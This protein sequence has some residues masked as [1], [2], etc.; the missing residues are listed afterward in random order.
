MQSVYLIKFLVIFITVFLLYA[1]IRSQLKISFLLK[2]HSMLIRG[3]I[4]LAFGTLSLGIAEFVAMG[5]LPYIANDFSVSLDTAGHII[6]F[7]ASGVA[8][9]A[10]SLLFL[11]R[12]K[13]KY[14]IL[15]LIIVHILGNALTAFA[16]DFNMLLLYRFISG[17]PHGCYFGVGSIIASR[18]ATAGKGTSAIAIMGAGM[19]VAN[20]FGVP[21]GT[22]MADTLSWRS[23]FYLVTLWGIIVLFSV[24]VFVKDTGKIADTGFKGQFV[25]LK[26]KAPWLILGATMFSNGGIFCL[27]SYLS[28]IL[29]KLSNIPLPMVSI[30]MVAMGICMVLFNLLSGKLCDKFAPGKVSTV[31]IIFSTFILICISILG[32]FKYA[33]IPLVCLSGGV[34]FATSAPLQMLIL[35]VSSGG[36]LL[37]ASCIQAAFNLGNA[38]G[39]FVGGL[40]FIFALDLHFIPL[41]GSIITFIGL[42]CMYCFA[43]FCEQNFTSEHPKTLPGNENLN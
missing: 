38:L 14:I 39:A 24:A 25:F 43:K 7:Y 29:T 27:L 37:G 26:N 11:R 10:F 19:T 8:F 22:A 36:Q 40:A 1:A 33:A 41:F 34:L 28:P 42:I 32:E 30:I 12:F 6:S 5:L 17:L 9:G 3:L 13:L 23:I 31:W 20:V 21:L 35:R 15:C 16:N 4:A 18:L 2:G